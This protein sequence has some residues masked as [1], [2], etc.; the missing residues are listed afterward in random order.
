MAN[1]KRHTGY[2]SGGGVEELV[3]L[4]L[5]LCFYLCLLLFLVIIMCP[6]FYSTLCLSE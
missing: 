6:L 4:P 3:Q 2:V 5:D 1:G